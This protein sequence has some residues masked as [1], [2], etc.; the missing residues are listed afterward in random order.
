MWVGYITVP[1]NGR[2]FLSHSRFSSCQ[3]LKVSFRRSIKHFIKII[4]PILKTIEQNSRSE[5]R[6]ALFDVF[7]QEMPMIFS[8]LGK[9]DCCRIW[10]QSYVLCPGEMLGSCQVV[11]AERPSRSRIC[12]DSISAFRKQ[13]HTIYLKHTIYS[14]GLLGWQVWSLPRGLS[15]S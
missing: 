10:S 6:R 4:F 5:N 13:K 7:H 2:R 14:L 11:S 15:P 12:E 1:F 8:L 3:K 9:W